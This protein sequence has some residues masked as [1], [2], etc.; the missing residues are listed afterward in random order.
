MKTDTNLE[1]AGGFA[2]ETQMEVP[3]ESVNETRKR[4]PITAERVQRALKKQGI[5]FDVMSPTMLCGPDGYIIL[6]HWGGRKPTIEICMHVEV[7]NAI[8]G[9]AAAIAKE[10]PY[11]HM[12]TDL[13]HF[14]RWSDEAPT[15]IRLIEVDMD[16]P[17]IEDPDAEDSCITVT[18]ATST[19][20]NKV[21]L[22]Y[23]AKNWPKMKVS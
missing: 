8:G 2:N 13:I 16:I 3:V 11:R 4:N 10:V 6:K 18:T 21:Y 20:D 9:I 5:D 14:D 19:D 23:L 22:E 1:I 7:Y 12:S 17:E 15:K